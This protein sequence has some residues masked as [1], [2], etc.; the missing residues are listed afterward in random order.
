MGKAN[1]NNS[2]ESYFEEYASFEDVPVNLRAQIRDTMFQSHYDEAILKE[3]PKCLR[4]MPH[5]QNTSGFFITMIEKVA[6]MDGAAPDLETEDKSSVEPPVVIQNDPKMKDF[7]FFR[8]EIQD[9]DVEYIQAYYG[10]QRGIFPTG[11]L[12]T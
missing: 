3:L 4:V 11:Q 2:I 1:D 9:P 7:N 5:H 10:L 8:C 6:E 12:I